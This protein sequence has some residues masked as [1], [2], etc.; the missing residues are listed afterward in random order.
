MRSRYENATPNLCW[1]FCALLGVLCNYKGG[2]CRDCI[3]IV[4]VDRWPLA[5]TGWGGPT[6]T[7]REKQALS[8]SRGDGQR[9]FLTLLKVWELVPWKRSESF[10]STFII[11]TASYQM[12]NSFSCTMKSSWALCCSKVNV[13]RSIEPI[14]DLRIA[15]FLHAPQFL[16]LVMEPTSSNRGLVPHK[17]SGTSGTSEIREKPVSPASQSSWMLRVKSIKFNVEG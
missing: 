5:A 17:F 4:V 7:W 15:K 1:V 14:C 12:R 9:R 2:F 16:R 11:M 13:R 10:W 6:S 8:L 3:F